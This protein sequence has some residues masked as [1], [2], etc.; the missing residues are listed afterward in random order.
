[1]QRVGI[2]AHGSPEVLLFDPVVDLDERL[3]L[4]LRRTLHLKGARRYC[5]SGHVHPPSETADFEADKGERHV[6]CALALIGEFGHVLAEIGVVHIQ[7]QSRIVRPLAN[8]QFRALIFGRPEIEKT[9]G[10]PKPTTHFHIKWLEFG[11]VRPFAV[12]TKRLADANRETCKSPGKSRVVV[13]SDKNKKKCERLCDDKFRAGQEIGLGK[14]LLRR[15]AELVYQSRLLRV[16]VQ[17]DL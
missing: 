11:E 14:S 2:L 6:S 10:P 15:K 12:E 1:M 13:P 17:L 8:S 4:L 7:G 5:A 9:H 3:L 16:K